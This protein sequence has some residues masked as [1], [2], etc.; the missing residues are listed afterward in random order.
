MPPGDL[1]DA[2]YQVEIRDLLLGVGTSYL[3]QG[4]EGIHAQA[5]K[6]ADLDLIGDGSYAG[7]DFEASKKPVLTVIFAADDPVDLQDLLDDFL[8]AWAIGGDVE[9]HWQLAGSHRYLVGRT[10]RVAVDENRRHAGVIEADAEFFAADPTVH[11]V[12]GS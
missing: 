8:D 6:T 4:L 9:L 5:V 10:R 12:T 1:I 11:I 7:E 3:V 2:D